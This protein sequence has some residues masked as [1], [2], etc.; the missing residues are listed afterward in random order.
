MSVQQLNREAMSLPLAERVALAQ[1][2]WASINR[3]FP[4]A[5][6]IDAIEEAVCRDAELSAGAVAGRPYEDVMET[7]RRAISCE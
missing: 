3:E 6:E 2:L 1:A 4:A 7:A 5:E